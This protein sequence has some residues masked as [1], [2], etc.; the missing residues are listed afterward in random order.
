MKNL[1]LKMIKIY[2]KVKGPWHNC[3]RY[4]PTCSNYAIESITTY[5]FLKGWSLAIAR[6]LRCNPFGGYGYDPVP[7]NLS[8]TKRRK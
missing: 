8:K 2:Q 6:I 4:Y 7:T 5:G 1:S 3:C